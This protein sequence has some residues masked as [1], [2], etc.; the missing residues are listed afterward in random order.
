M[1]M[2]TMLV[3]NDDDGAYRMRMFQDKREKKE[4]KSGKGVPI[5]NYREIYNS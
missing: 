1:T 5:H 4:V 3:D 2:M